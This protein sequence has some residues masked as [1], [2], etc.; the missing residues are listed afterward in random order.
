M[1]S[2]SFIRQ[3]PYGLDGR[4]RHAIYYVFRFRSTV[5]HIG[6]GVSQFRGYI[7]A[8]FPLFIGSPTS[9]I[10][11]RT[12]KISHR[13]T[14]YSANMSA[15][16]FIKAV[17]TWHMVAKSGLAA[18]ERQA[19]ELKS[20][21]RYDSRK[22]TSIK[23]RTYVSASSRRIFILQIQKYFEY[24]DEDEVNVGSSSRYTPFYRAVYNARRDKFYR[25]GFV[26][27]FHANVAVNGNGN[28]RFFF[29]SL[30]QWRNIITMVPDHAIHRST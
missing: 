20:S 7:P 19:N 25:L 17:Y 14:N 6:V 28:P 22:F 24:N 11:L 9:W 5:I 1:D 29:L 16:S 26:M 10:F 21:S 18:C 13:F 4:C 15:V 27:K 3:F 2:L 23:I 30:V 12:V 8:L